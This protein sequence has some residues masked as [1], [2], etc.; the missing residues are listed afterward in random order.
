MRNIKKICDVKPFQLTLEFDNNE[1]RIID[2]EAD[3]KE[4]SRSPESK[5]RQLLDPLEFNK[6]KLNKEME[7]IYWD[8]GI[9]L[10]PDVLWEK[11]IDF[12]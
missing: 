4:W 8:N 11:G 9:D 1:I 6:V 5:F 3:F 12:M 10:C 2:L 7:Y